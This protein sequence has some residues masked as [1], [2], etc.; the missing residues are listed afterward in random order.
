MWGTGGRAWGGSRSHLRNEGQIVGLLARMGDADSREG[1]CGR[2]CVQSS[3]AA[4]T[5]LSHLRASPQKIF[6]TAFG[7]GH[8]KPGGL[9]PASVLLANYPVRLLTVGACNF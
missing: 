3:H 5:V 6:T 4:R 8:S 2:Q 7:D 1:S 9:A